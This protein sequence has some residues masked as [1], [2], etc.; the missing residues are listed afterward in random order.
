MTDLGSL[1][2][3]IANYSTAIEAWRGEL[4]LQWKPW[5]LAQHTDSGASFVI[6]TTSSYCLA[7]S[8]KLMAAFAQVETSLDNF[9]QFQ[10]TLDNFRQ[11]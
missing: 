8:G 9:R 2:Q 3:L 10:T 1:R 11:L 5:G 4:A 7:T 6:L